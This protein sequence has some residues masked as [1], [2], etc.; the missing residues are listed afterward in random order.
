MDKW[1]KIFLEQDWV[2]KWPIGAILPCEMAFF[3]AVCEANDVQIIIES[4]RQDGYSTEIIGYYAEEKS[5]RAYS[6][7]IEFDK[8]RADRCRRRLG[9]NPY[10]LMLTGRSDDWIGPLLSADRKTLTALLID[11]PKG[12]QAISMLLAAA[13]FKNVCVL[14]V[15]NLHFNMNVEERNTFVQLTPGPHFY[16]EISGDIGSN[17]NTLRE[18]EIAHRKTL[19][20][21]RAFDESSLG[22]TQLVGAN[23]R[24]LVM[25]TKPTK[26]RLRPPIQFYIKWK[27]PGL[28]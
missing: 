18:A 1:S 17:W 20:P 28:M 4:G 3:L 15:H 24:N 8:E 10:L 19:E 13:G 14:A 25:T 12:Y 16:E 7:D 26:F 23:R 6:I 9:G 22:I 21:D 27:L 5:G 11:G 2:L